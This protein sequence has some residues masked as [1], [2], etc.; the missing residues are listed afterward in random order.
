MDG[1]PPPGL[2]GSTAT[3]K[4]RTLPVPLRFRPFRHLSPALWRII[5]FER[6]E[7]VS[8]FRGPVLS[9]TDMASSVFV[10]RPFLGCWSPDFGRQI[11]L[12]GT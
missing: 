11:T 5:G 9:G 7:H 10:R 6:E 2:S 1:A 3:A 8:G 4:N 12:G